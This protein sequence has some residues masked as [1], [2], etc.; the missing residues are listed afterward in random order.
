[1]SKKSK[2]GGLIVKQD[3][4]LPSLK[5]NTDNYF[6]IDDRIVVYH[7]DK[8]CHGVIKKFDNEKKGNEFVIVQLED[9]KLPLPFKAIDISVCFDTKM[10]YE[11]ISAFKEFYKSEY[12]PMGSFEENFYGDKIDK[13]FI[14]FLNKHQK[15]DFLRS[16][17]LNNTI[18]GD[19]VIF[20]ES[21]KFAEIIS[22]DDETYD[23]TIFEIKI[24]DSLLKVKQSELKPIDE[25]VNRLKKDDIELIYCF[26]KSLMD[27][28][29]FNERL[30]FINFCEYFKLPIA[31]VVVALPYL[32]KKEI[33][34]GMTR[35][36]IEKIVGYF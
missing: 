12:D 3:K 5:S 7:K 36:N 1:M 22:I 27:D 35:E 20:A 28:I 2:V 8:W 9:E 15:F 31:T 11:P 17:N 29:Y 23:E 32:I 21:S 34:S 14:R 4:V 6:S 16:I 26:I 33:F 18:E 25:F 10:S 24:N 30:F 13:F 19:F